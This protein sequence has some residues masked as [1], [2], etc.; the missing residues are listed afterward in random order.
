MRTLLATILVLLVALPAQAQITFVGSG[1][2]RARS[3]AGTIT[4]A[5]PGGTAAGDLAVLI[6]VGRPTNTT[7]PAAPAGWTLRTSVLQQ[8]SSTDLKVMTFYR[9]LAGADANPVVTLPAAWVG[10]SAG[11]SGQI[12][13]W[14]GAN[15][16]TPFDVADT[17]GVANPDDLFVAPAIT[18]VTANARVVSVVGTSDNNNLGL[19]AAASFT[20]QMSG[21][22]YDT[23]IGGDHA[24]GVADKVQAAAGLVA[25]P[26]WEQNNAEPD[27]WAAITFA[28]RPP[29]AQRLSFSFD[30]PSWTGAAGEVVD[31]STFGL[32][33]TAFGGATTANT[34]PALSGNPGTCRYGAFDGSADYVEVPDNNALDITNELTVAA[35][36][37]MRSAPPELHTIVS[38]DTNYE[39]HIDTQR[40]V[41]WWWND[42]NGNVRSITT[43][44]Q[45]A[46]NTWYHVAVTYSSGAQRIYIN[47]NVQ[48]TTGN[49]TGTLATNALP[50][51]VGTDYN[52]PSRIFDGYIDEVRVVADALTAAEIVA[53]RDETH[54]CANQARFTITHNAFGINCVAETIT[55]DVVDAV[56]GTPLLNYNAQVQLDTQ[57]GFGTWTLVTGTGAFSDGAAGD[58]VATYTWPL[59][60]SQATFT[61][62]YPQGPPSIDV[63]VFQVSNTA[64]RDNDAEGALVFSPNGFSVTAAALPNPPG[65]VTPFATSQT[66]GTNF[67]LYLAAYG[68]TPSDPVCGIIEAYTGAKNVKFW[69]QYVNPGT[70]TRNAT[71][72]TVAIAA[73]E[74][75]SAAQAVTF[76]N[77]Q[78]VVTAKYKDVGSI[79]IALKDDTTVNAELPAGIQGATANFVVKPYEFVLSGIADAANTVVNP[80]A[81]DASGAVFLAAGAPFRATVT[82]RDAEGAATPNY[83]R[84]T[85]AEG[86]RL[87]AQI[88]APAGGA[89]PAIG[90]TVGF[91]AFANGVATGTDF[92]WSEVGILRAVPGVG[93]ADYLLAGDVTGALS[94]R[95]GRFIP[96]R[97]VAALNAPTF[98]TA[99]GVGGFTYQGQSFGYGAAPVITAT[100]V[101]AGGTTTTNYTNGAFFK[102]SNATL[103]GRT[104]TGASALDTSGLPAAGVDPA[105]AIA[106]PG[107]ATLTFSSGAGLEF[108]KGAPVAP[109]DANLQLA[110]NVI[111]GDGVVAVGAAPLGNPVTF[112]S[113]GGITFDAGQQIRYGRVRV[114]TA[115]G[116]ERVDLPVPMRAE[117]FASAAAGFVTN[118]SDA[119]S[120]NVSLAFSG[121]TENLNAGETCVRDSGAPGASGAGCA[122]VA[123]LPVRYREPPVTG[124]FNL[125]L[126][127]PGIGNQGSVVITA[128]VPDFLRFDW[129]TG[130]AGDEN[131]TGQATFGI[132]GGESRQIYTREIY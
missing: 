102:L 47:G 5:L 78:A 38:K 80:Q 30:E 118:L 75:A 74:A 72:D 48:A 105:I 77:G 10:S 103:T 92:T 106:G 127:A 131:P 15:T 81:L 85:P 120:T 53:L 7:E 41:Y 33:G 4:P 104:Y 119:C 49:F 1:A 62:Y 68:Q 99:C 122:A 91:G 54:P 107:I 123:P 113:T 115:V 17:T 96:S 66:A 100:A 23:A 44:T 132:F 9:V 26:E 25:M 31:D 65:A 129:N 90:S 109:F 94:E 130:T 37:Y 14:R 82:V 61:L 35:W 28:L 95:I 125:R 18:T 83:G 12:A 84:E 98:L 101:A 29:P 69:S 114:G 87:A 43:T 57:S 32:D 112:G 128:T 76:T 89:S 126:A 21:T 73:T 46:L 6:V 51:Y 22:G 27:R 93:D 56:A 116:S 117:Y 19:N 70:G 20:A 60:E 121:Y 97:F 45:I 86:V 42:S 34:T 55:V 40:R 88:F 124:D 108:V 79:R 16:S 8:V 39:Y 71:I 67:A 52:F 24:M 63:D 11:M 111:D 3:S 2:Q 36:I 58:G 13:V 59:G 64:I 110:I 50:F